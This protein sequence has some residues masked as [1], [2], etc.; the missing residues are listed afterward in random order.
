[1]KLSSGYNEVKLSQT[2][3]AL[4]RRDKRKF[5]ARYQNVIRLSVSAA[6]IMK[7]PESEEMAP[8]VGTGAG[9]S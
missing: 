6:S 4:F 3:R 2:H 9:S 1:L 8:A 5:T 7:M